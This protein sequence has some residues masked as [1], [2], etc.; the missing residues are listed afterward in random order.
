MKREMQFQYNTKPV[1]FHFVSSKIR[2]NSVFKVTK[3]VCSAFLLKPLCSAFLL[4]P[5]DRHGILVYT[6]VLTPVTKTVQYE[7]HFIVLSF[8]F[9]G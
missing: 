2:H 7:L 1:Y 8:A 4:K 5:L 6:C 9:G 3:P